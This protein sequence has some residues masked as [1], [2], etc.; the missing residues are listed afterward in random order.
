MTHSILDIHGTVVDHSG[1]LNGELSSVEYLYQHWD[2]QFPVDPLRILFF[3]GGKLKQID[4][5]NKDAYY[6]GAG[7][8]I[9]VSE[10]IISGYPAWE[11]RLV[12]ARELQFFVRRINSLQLNRQSEEF[13]NMT[14][15]AMKTMLPLK[16]LAKDLIGQPT[17]ESLSVKYDCPI[18]VLRDYID[19]Y[20]SKGR[21]PKGI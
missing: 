2:H 20:V 4:R 19:K 9:F 5:S 6:L 14:K 8:T 11:S 18:S 3:L 10:P 17:I 12:I 1:H 16:D 7:S 13:L 15:M 21:L